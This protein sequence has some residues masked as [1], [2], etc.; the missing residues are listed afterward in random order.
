MTIAAVMLGSRVSARVARRRTSATR[1]PGRSPWA[2]RCASRV[3]SVPGLVR[4][5]GEQQLV[6]R[7][8]VAV[9]RAQR[10]LGPR[11]DVA[12]L[13]RVVAALGRELDRGLEQP[14]PPRARSPAARGVGC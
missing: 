4:E 11:R 10:D 9:Q 6:L 13:H 1:S 8:V 2:G 5:R 14:A 12:H 7:R 3:R